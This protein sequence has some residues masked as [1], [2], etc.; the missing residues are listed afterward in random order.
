MAGAGGPENVNEDELGNLGLTD[1]EEDVVAF[2]ETLTDRVVVPV[3]L[4]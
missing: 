3:P 4:H 1:E 2:M